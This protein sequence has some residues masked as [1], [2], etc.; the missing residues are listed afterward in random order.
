MTFANSLDLDQAR[1]NVMPDLDLNHWTR[2]NSD[3]F[4]TLNEIIKCSIF[5]IHLKNVISSIRGG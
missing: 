5:G 3:V 2:E 1:Q 4:N